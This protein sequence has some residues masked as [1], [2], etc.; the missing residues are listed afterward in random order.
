MELGKQFR[1]VH[2]VHVAVAHSA[3]VV[4]AH[5]VPL[6]S[7]WV[8]EHGVGFDDEFEFFFVSALHK[9]VQKAKEERTE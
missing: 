5:V 7:L 4:I 9:K 8:G 6:A 1:Q 3:I 2:P